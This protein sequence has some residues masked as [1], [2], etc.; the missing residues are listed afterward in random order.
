MNHLM[1]SK[2]TRHSALSTSLATSAF[3]LPTKWQRDTQLTFPSNKCNIVLIGGIFNGYQFKHKPFKG[4]EHHILFSIR[5]YHAT[6]DAGFFSCLH[7]LL[8][9]FGNLAA[10]CFRGKLNSVQLHQFYNSDYYYCRSAAV[11]PKS[12]SDRSRVMAMQNQKG[13]E[14]SL[15]ISEAFFFYNFCCTRFDSLPNN[16]LTCECH[17]VL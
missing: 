9:H 2:T 4:L 5:G 17:H 10:D 16:L 3:L 1:N 6:L 12:R 14:V 13:F 8:T 15:D 7:S 11:F